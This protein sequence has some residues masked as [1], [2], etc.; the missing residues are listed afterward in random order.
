M[1]KKPMRKIWFIPI[2]IVVVL[3]LAALGFVV[4]GSMAAQP[5]PEALAAMQSDAQVRV[6]TNSWLEFSPAATE[7]STGLI[8]YPGGKVDPRAYAPA[9]HTLAAQGYLV[10][11]VPMPLNLAVFGVDR[12]N[13]VIA[14]YPSIRHWAIGGHS[15]GGSMAANYA[16]RH[17]ERIRGLA[18]WAAYPADSDDMSKVATAVTSISA[19]NDGLSTP[20]KIAR[21]KPL[22]PGSTRFVVIE[23]GNHAQ[24][25][26]YGPQD[27][28]KPAT[29]SRE[30]QQR[31]IILAT[32]D[33]LASLK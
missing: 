29:I 16:L 4:W 9:A 17:T 23:G 12:A 27:G 26:W 33:L 31:Q 28:D 11:I 10:V 7:P 30:E 32:A 24:F 6:Q 3:A 15:L 2:G 18:L 20:E 8:L 21:T 25:G 1:R 13:D 5:M 22:L 14:A 19:T